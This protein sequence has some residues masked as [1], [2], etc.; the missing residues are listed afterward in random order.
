MN[1]LIPVLFLSLLATLSG[2]EPRAKPPSPPYVRPVP[3]GSAWGVKIVAPAG[4]AGA[5]KG[6]PVQ[7]TREVG[8][9]GRQRGEIINADGEKILFFLVDGYILQKYDHSDRVALFPAPPAAAVGLPD[10]LRSP[11]FPDLDWVS[12]RT[13]QGT[14]TLNGEPCHR[15]A[16]G[17]SGERGDREVWI[18]ISDRRPARLRSG[19]TTFEFSPVRARPGEMMLPPPFQEALKRLQ[20][21]LRAL[22]AM[23]TRQ[24]P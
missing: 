15:Y 11:A 19:A 7:M 6:I 4:K 16:T 9:D 14:E 5:G 22:K 1:K 2:A 20:A 10:R 17:K 23:K 21:E 18:R 24:K 8:G 12:A 13:Y 3:E